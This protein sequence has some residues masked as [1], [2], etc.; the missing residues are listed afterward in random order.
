M[1]CVKVMETD[2]WGRFKALNKLLLVFILATLSLCEARKNAIRS[3]FPRIK[4]NAPAPFQD[5][6]V[7]SFF[8]N[9][10]DN[11]ELIYD[12]N[13]KDP[14]TFIGQEEVPFSGINPYRT[15]T[16]VT[17]ASFLAVSR[18]GFE[19]LK[20]TQTL[21]SSELNCNFVIGAY[22][23]YTYAMLGYTIKAVNNVD[24]APSYT[25]LLA[26]YPTLEIE[27]YPRESGED[28]SIEYVFPPTCD[29]YE[30][31]LISY[32]IN[33][34]GVVG[35]DCIPNIVI[36]SSTTACTEPTGKYEK[37]LVGYKEG[38]FYGDNNAAKEALIK[39]GPIFYGDVEKLIIGWEG[40]NW[41]T[42]GQSET[43][44]YILDSEPISSDVDVDVD[45]LM[46]TLYA[47]F[48]GAGTQ[49]TPD[50]T[51]ITKD[52]P[53]ESC[54]CPEKTD[55]AK[56]DADPRTETEDDI[57][58]SGSV[59]ITLSVIAAALVLPVLALFF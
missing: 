51:T 28:D 38:T 33:K 52:T 43:Y 39:F 13:G 17:D 53:K 57:C 27:K 26:N 40:T 20:T 34:F 16:A 30:A 21:N 1:E 3:K 24:I 42:V 6:V 15:G 44:E 58:A 31:D 12:F 47:N 19:N 55:K 7:Y 32:V 2:Y 45:L 22:D 8:G 41:V 54:P 50:C 49:V 4:A 11:R 10:N 23:Y 18:E 9:M 59:H 29:D 36:P 56:W 37:Q 48:G 35:T 46:G 14:D 25:Y 5:K